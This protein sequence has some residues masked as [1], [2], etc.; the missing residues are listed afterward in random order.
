MLLVTHFLAVESDKDVLDILY[1]KFIAW[2]R[3]LEIHRLTIDEEIEVVTIDMTLNKGIITIPIDTR[4]TPKYSKYKVII[5][6]LAYGKE[7][8]AKYVKS[9]ISALTQLR[10]QLESWTWKNIY[11][12]KG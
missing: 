5:R 10:Q 6:Y 11:Q 8:L 4:G 2:G 7:A 9:I 12:R 3:A 1:K